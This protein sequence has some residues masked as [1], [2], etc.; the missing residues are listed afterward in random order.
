[1]RCGDFADRSDSTRS[2]RM[3]RRRDVALRF[4][5]ELTFQHHLADQHDRS[6][7]LPD[8][9]LQGDVQ[10]LGQGEFAQRRIG[11]RALVVVR[12]DAPAGGFQVVQELLDQSHDALLRR[13]PLPAWAR[14]S[15]AA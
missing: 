7:R 3:H 4:G 2:R 13:P 6:R 8:M 15:V 5:D 14:P 1:M 12:M 9:L 11:C 10:A